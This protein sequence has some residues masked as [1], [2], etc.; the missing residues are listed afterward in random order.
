MVEIGFKWRNDE[1]EF[2]LS[3]FNGCYDVAYLKQGDKGSIART[4]KEDDYSW[5]KAK[6]LDD[7]KS[8]V[9]EML[10]VHLEN[11]ILKD[12]L[13]IEELKSTQN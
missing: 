6:T 4:Y 13:I 5:L 1:N 11:E 10:K 12:S 9:V 3:V 7:A 8:E 2:V